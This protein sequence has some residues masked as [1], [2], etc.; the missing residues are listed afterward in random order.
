MG[1]AGDPDRAPHP[2]PEVRRAFT[3][4]AGQALAKLGRRDE[5]MRTLHSAVAVADELVGQPRRWQARAALGRVAYEFGEDDIAS[6][7]YEQ[8]E[9]SSTPSRRRSYRSGPARL[10][11]DPEVEEILRSRAVALSADP[12]IRL[13]AVGE[14]MVDVVS[15]EQPAEERVRTRTSRFGWAARR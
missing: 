1:R 13:I 4:I 15:R 7:A 2:A 10:Q 3:E 11:A 8:A 5:A 6:S 9:G 14:V 12:R